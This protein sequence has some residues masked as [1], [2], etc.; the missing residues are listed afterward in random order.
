MEPG[1]GLPVDDIDRLIHEPARLM[2]MAY[3][4]VVDSADFIFLM[5]Q[6]GLT[7][8][9]LSAHMSKLEAAGYIE[10]AKDF[11]D[12]KPHTMLRLTDKGRDAFRQYRKR[13]K[14][15]LDSLPD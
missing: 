3:L 1:T 9:N 4:Y 15:V 11:V 10:V 12:K 14:G 6:T 8:G 7:W 2:I 13:M 5:R